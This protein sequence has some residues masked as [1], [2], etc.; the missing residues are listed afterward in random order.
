MKLN[1]QKHYALRQ[2][3]IESKKYYCLECNKAFRDKYSLDKHLN[4]LKHH[5]ERKIS[6]HCASC[7]YT[8]KFK[9]C[10]TQHLHTKKH[11]NNQ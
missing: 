9:H 11:I 1:L 6:Y 7:N 8:T 2:S 3:D 4:G 5:P 10:L